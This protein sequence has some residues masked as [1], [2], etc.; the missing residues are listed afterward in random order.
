MY[1]IYIDYSNGAIVFLYEI[2]SLSTFGLVRYHDLPLHK[3]KGIILT[4]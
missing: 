4:N 3:I 2:L 1:I